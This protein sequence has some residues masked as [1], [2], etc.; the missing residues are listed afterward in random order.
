MYPALAGNRAV[1][2]A[3]HLNVVKSIRHGGFMPTTAGNRQPFGM[4]PYG[5]ELDEA[6][7]AA[8]STFIRQSWGNAASPVSTL[9]VLRVK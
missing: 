9:D 1:N 4:P 5:Q 3:S 2:L 7:I 6:E 8:V